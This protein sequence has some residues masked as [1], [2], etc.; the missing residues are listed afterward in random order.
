MLTRRPAAPEWT[1]TPSIMKHYEIRRHDADSW[2]VTC[3]PL[4]EDGR[5]LPFG[6]PV[7][8]SRSQEEARTWVSRMLDPIRRSR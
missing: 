2:W 1:M 8:F 5:P 6:R 3:S 4:G 7:Y